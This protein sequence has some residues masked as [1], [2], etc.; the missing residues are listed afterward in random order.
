[1]DSPRSGTAVVELVELQEFL[2]APA[3]SP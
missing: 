1:M 2:A 3:V